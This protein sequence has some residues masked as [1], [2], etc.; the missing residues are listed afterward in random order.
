MNSMHKGDRFIAVVLLVLLAPVGVS[1]QASSARA[2]SVE[3]DGVQLHYR[4][5]GSGPPLLL[6][7][8]F[9]GTGVWWDPYLASLSENYRTI[10]PDLPGHGRSRSGPHPYRFDHVAT[11][12]YRLMDE[13][14]I[15]R[16]RAIGY[17][18]GGIVLIHMATRQPGRMESMA[19]LSAPHLPSRANIVGFPSFED[20]PQRTREHWL[21]MHP[22]GEGQ[23]RELIASF[24][25]LEELVDE[26]SVTADQL[27]TIETRTL[28]VVGDRDPMI[29]LR[30]VMEM[31]RAVPEAALWVVPGKGHSALWPD[32]GGSVEAASIF[33]SVV[34]GFLGIEPL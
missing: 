17:S 6:L 25:A 14:E 28:L 18:G 8:G 13:L 15:D 21:E 1:A 19:V 11:D 12:M 24:H 23:V 10:V 34:T 5:A 7:H 29:P 4:I 2:D 22:G 30:G 20:H 26:I 33:P 9:T 32:W 16:F 31:Y 27:S 3:V